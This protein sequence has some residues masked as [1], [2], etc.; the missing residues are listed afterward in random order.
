LELVE[1]QEQQMETRGEGMAHSHLLVLL[2]LL[3]VVEVLERRL[4]VEP[5]D[6]VVEADITRTTQPDMEAEQLVDA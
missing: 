3:G 5:E 2:L 4:T 1:V 6:Q